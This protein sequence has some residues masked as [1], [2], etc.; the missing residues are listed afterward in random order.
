M[1]DLPQS[2]NRSVARRIQSINN[3]PEALEERCLLTVNF[4]FDY[5]YDT[6]D[7]FDTT[8]KR[9]A[10]EL[11]GQIVGAQLTDDLSAISPSGS[12]QWRAT[13]PRPD[14][15]VR[16]EV[17][18]PDVAANE[19]LVFVGARDLGSTVGNGG[20]G[21]YWVSGSS[22]FQNAVATRGQSGVS[23]DTDFGPWGGQLT[24][25]TT[26]DYHFGETVEGLDSSETDFMS[27]AIHEIYHMMGFGLSD[28]FET[29]VNGAGDFT[30]S[31]AVAEYDGS[32]NVPLSSSESHFATSTDDEGRETAMDPGIL[33][34]TRKLPTLLDRA[35]L[36]DMGW[37]YDLSEDMDFG[38]APNSS[39]PTRASSNGARHILG[40]GLELGSIAD[41]DSDGQ[42]NSA[43]SG[44]D[45]D[46][47]DDDDG[48]IFNNVLQA[49]TTVSIDV[50]ASAAGGQL[51][52]WVDFNADGDWDDSGEQIFSSQALAE[53]TNELTF[54]VPSGIT[55]AT[56]YARFRLSSAGGLDYDGLAADGEVED[57][58][59][60]IV[61][62][63][64]AIDD[65]YGVTGTDTLNVLANDFPA[66]EVRVQSYS[67]P[68]NASVADNFD[69]TLEFTPD[70]GFSGDTSFTYTIRF[71]QDKV[72]GS[73]TDAGDEFGDAVAISGDYAIVGVNAEDNV[74]GTDAGAAYI[75]ERTGDRTWT[76]IKKLTASDGVE[77]DRFGYSVAIDGTTV[78]VGARSADVTGT[79]DGA[80]YIFNK[81]Q[82]GLDSWG[83]VQKVIGSE[84][85]AKDQFGHSVA[86]SG[87][88]VAVG[89]RLDDGDGSASGSVYIFER[90]LGGADNWGERVR[91]KASDAEKG[92]QFG[93]AVAIDGNNLLVGARKDDDA[94]TD[95]GSVYFLNRDQGGNDAWGEFNK[96]TAPDGV[97]NDW[98]GTSVDLDGN[99]A[100]VGKPIRNNRLRPGKA[101]T[102][103][104]DG[105]AWS[106]VTTF[107]ATSNT[108][109]DQ[110]GYSV[111]IEG[112]TAIVGA[113][114]EDSA[115]QNAGMIAVHSRNTGGTNNWGLDYDLFQDE[116]TQGDYF[117]EAIAIS[118]DW[119][120]GGSPFDDD[121]GSKSGSV[122]F[123]E[124]ATTDS[125][126]VNVTVGQAGGQGGSGG[127][128]GDDGSGSGSGS[129]EGGS[130]NLE[131]EEVDSRL[132]LLPMATSDST[133]AL[134]N[135]GDRCCC[136]AC[137]AAV[138]VVGLRPA[139][140]PS[141]GP[142]FGT[143]QLH[144][145][146]PPVFESVDSLFGVSLDLFG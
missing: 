24:F 87:D 122:S 93:F 113:R 8:A 140:D 59:L 3:Q 27:V 62:E 5:R 40:S 110:F 34:G 73:S 50:T 139:A 121:E 82:G 109:A 129:G 78:V 38:D 42:N 138:P 20:F 105:P 133:G 112:N 120:V 45:N 77:K 111:A 46:E 146:L 135:E 70:N 51:D 115:V 88:T 145:P 71:E 49:G 15:G 90:N 98:F 9:D 99:Y 17:S 69:G 14:T 6:S 67:Q 16:V 41:S 101:Y 100:I 10:L 39:Y 23:N 37:E 74:N 18:N 63:I 64:A 142:A 58:Q 66:N 116:A 104:K 130:G 21:G 53:G 60:E 94:G 85:S 68:A 75:F 28:S 36:V 131:R 47:L 137:L 79:N 81:D 2:R 106:Y 29:Q 4:N 1:F 118:G 72:D 128:S 97:K 96:F 144:G 55:N 56:T 91:I 26:T 80:V 65:D 126:T 25:S 83:L 7:F 103:S 54:D 102:Y 86:I 35:V 48:V 95:G 127:G 33:N 114:L 19:L 43:A 119:I 22:S 32:G 76:Q 52:A 132:S 134:S 84:N 108:D 125:G 107:G 92:D 57:Y 143:G 44:D 136:D 123:Q 117:G 11:A 141:A 124:I 89:A 30:G 31:N 61:G 13:F 12:N